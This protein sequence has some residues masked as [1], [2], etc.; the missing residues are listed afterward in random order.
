MQIAFLGFGLIAGAI[1]Q[2]V[3]TDPRSLG[4]RMTAWSPSGDGPRR[5][6]SDGA[7]DVVA[8]SAPEA[9]AGAD[10]II[11]AAPAT[12]CLSLIDAIAGEWSVAM[13]PDTVVTDVASTKVMLVDRADAA[14]IR[15]VGGHPMAGLEVAGYR[16]GTAGLFVDRPW[17]IVPGAHADATDV[18]RVG[19]VVEACSAR[20]M[21]M[22]AAA[23]D[24][25]V[26]AVSHLPL[27]AAAAVVEAMVASSDDVTERWPAAKAL[28]AGG[29]RDTTRVARGDPAMGAAIVATNAAELAARV[30]ELQA[31]LDAWLI[32][33]ERAGGPDEVAIR[34]RLAAARAALGDDR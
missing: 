11:L 32:A 19:A 15:F 20:S 21:V 31:V 24:R 29:W 16:P 18:A 8:A 3:R 33:L 2:S 12:V 7:I 6:A 34:D 5:A 10:L 28:A 30:R 22:D 17:V 9:I 4:W 1:A 13:R 23:H 14:G 27:I 26:S 25:A